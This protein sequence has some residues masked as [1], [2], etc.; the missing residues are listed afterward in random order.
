MAPKVTLEIYSDFNCVW[1][2]FNERHIK[3]LKRE[4]AIDVVWRAFP[5]HPDAPEEGMPIKF[6]FGNSL[7]IMNDKM[8]QLERKAAEL[9]LPLKSRSM[10]SNSRL[11]QELGKWADSLGRIDDFHEA[12]Y[13]A[14]FKEGLDIAKIPILLDVAESAH[15]SREDAR[16]VLETRSFKAAVDKDWELSENLDITAAPTY[17]VQNDKLVGAEPYE[18]IEQLLISNGA[19]KKAPAAA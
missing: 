8:Q 1:C 17:V 9:G 19:R 6:L 5:L 2:Y 16:T 15:L 13:R 12:I 7:E 18:K 4:Y 3:K 11:S 10:I 14:Y